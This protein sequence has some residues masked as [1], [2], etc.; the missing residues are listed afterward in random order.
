MAGLNARFSTH[1][2]S[3]AAGF[4]W[5]VKQAAEWFDGKSHTERNFGGTEGF[6]RGPGFTAEELDR[7]RCIVHRRLVYNAF[8]LHGGG[9]ADN[10][11]RTALRDY[12][13]VSDPLN[14]TKMLTKTG[15]ILPERDVDEILGMSIFDRLRCVRD[16]ASSGWWKSSP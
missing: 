1:A 6:L 14:H 15:R 11:E 2:K 7:V 13:T 12:H 9:V 4:D 3:T 5:T 10:V 8:N 16:V